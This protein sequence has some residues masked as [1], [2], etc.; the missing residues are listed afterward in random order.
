[1]LE[2]TFDAFSK[3]MATFLVGVRLL[4]AL[5]TS[6]LLEK[7]TEDFRFESDNDAQSQSKYVDSILSG[8]WEPV[9]ISLMLTR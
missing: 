2:F 4:H 8:Y 6:F 1:M 5:V 7:K 3:S 9:L